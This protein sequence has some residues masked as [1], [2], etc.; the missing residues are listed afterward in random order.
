MINYSKFYEDIYPQQYD[1]I[2]NVF[3]ADYK[4]FRCS[5]DLSEDNSQILYENLLSS[6]NISEL[7]RKLL[8]CRY[9]DSNNHT[10]KELSRKFRL[11]DSRIQQRL[12][13]VERK[14]KHYKNVVNCLQNFDK[15]GE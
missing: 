13:T 1:K 8:E 6:I 11:S 14:L 5:I 2:H 3:N 7:D 12:K 15:L 10:F 9:D 4:D